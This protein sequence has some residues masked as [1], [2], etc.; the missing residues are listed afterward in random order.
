MDQIVTFDVFSALIDSRSGGSALF[1]TL[2]STRGWEVQ[3]AGLFDRWDRLNKESHR[4]Q[5]AWASF[6]HLSERALEAVYSEFGLPTA[7][8]AR[9]SDA[10]LASMAEWPLWPDVS[11]PSL[12]GLGVERLGLLSNIDDDLLAATAPLR[13]GV[14]DPGSIVTSERLRAYKPNRSFYERAAALLGPFTHIASS[15]RDVRGAV[16]A[17]LSCIRLA[18]PGHQLDPEGP[19]PARTADSIRELGELLRAGRVPHQP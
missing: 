5:H 4:T 16:S 9:D 6:R 8:A 3:G 19:A 11:V 18:R 12:T 13:L 7:D 10:L 1:A 17:H 15:A 2:A 14:F